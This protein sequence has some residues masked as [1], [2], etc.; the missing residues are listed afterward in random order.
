MIE[1]GDDHAGTEI[2]DRGRA[3]RA[4]RR[5][6]RPGAAAQG[7][8]TPARAGPRLAGRV[9]VLPGGDL[10]GR[11]QLRRLAQGRPGRLRARPRRHARSSIPER[12]GNRRADGC[13]NVA[14]QPA[15]R[16]DLPGARPRSTRCASTAGPGWSATRRSSTTWSSRVTDR[17]SPWWSRWSRCSTTARKAFLRS[18]LWEPES[19]GGPDLPTRAV[20][21][22]TLE[23]PDVALEALEQYY[24]RTTRR[25][26]TSS[27]APTCP[28]RADPRGSEDRRGRVGRGVRV[29]A[30]TAST[31]RRRPRPGRRRRR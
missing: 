21:A 6:E 26:C 25:V 28:R 11:R 29:R 24:G 14:D 15:R 31:G 8:G 1:A 13:R 4:A 3:A 17:C 22:R 10:G 23:R 9:A 19:W 7:A 16:A 12:P 5:A 18:Q 2:T 20:I 30:T 27:A